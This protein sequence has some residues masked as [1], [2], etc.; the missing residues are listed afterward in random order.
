MPILLDY[1]AIAMATMF[2]KIVDPK[3]PQEDLV[4]HLILNTIRMYNLK[5]RDK[6]GD[7]VICCDGGSWRK[8]V[9]PQ[10][11]AARTTAKNADEPTADW[12]EFYRIMNLVRDELAE[13]FPYR[14]VGIAGA[15]GDDVIAT[16]TT[17]AAVLKEKVMIVSR[18]H[19]F[20]QLQTY[21]NVAQFDPVTKKL[22]RPEQSPGRYAFE[23][24]LK[25]CG[26]DGIPNVLSKDD[27]FVTGT[28]Q[29]PLSKKKID[30][31]WDNK[32]RLGHTSVMPE[33]IYRNFMRNRTLVDFSGIPERIRAGVLTKYRECE[34]VPNSKVFP[35][36]VSKRCKNLLEC[37]GD[38]LPISKTPTTKYE[39]QL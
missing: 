3:K 8:E 39:F 9:F 21:D 11:K 28:R 1:S 4:R 6:C 30:F 17:T 15:E 16:L 10:Y 23:Q 36:L 31:W 14:V 32:E 27:V 7:T 38:F 18:D 29:T 37:A 25:G 24:I 33:E 20:F 13:H 2:S 26:G 19:D 5:F 22:V 34:V 12:P 35:F